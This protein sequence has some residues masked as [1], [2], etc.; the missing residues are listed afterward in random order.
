[1]KCNLVISIPILMIIGDLFQLHFYVSYEREEK[2]RN[3]A[4]GGG[5]G[6]GRGEMDDLHKP[7]HTTFWYIIF[8]V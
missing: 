2:Y 7:L 5:W 3:D 6:E 1:M 8:L 4:A